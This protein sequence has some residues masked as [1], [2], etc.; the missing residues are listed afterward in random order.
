LAIEQTTGNTG[1]EEGVASKVLAE[2]YHV[3][4]IIQARGDADYL[5]VSHVAHRLDDDDAMAGHEVPILRI[6]SVGASYETWILG[7]KS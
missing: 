5:D 3:L 4:S 7:G 6:D 1:V 2:L